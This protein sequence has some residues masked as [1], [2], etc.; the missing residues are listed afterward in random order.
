MAIKLD[1]W[2]QSLIAN[3]EAL[4]RRVAEALV[5]HFNQGETLDQECVAKTQEAI[6]NAFSDLNAMIRSTQSRTT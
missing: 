2:R 6:N 4:Q 5:V 1:D 3:N